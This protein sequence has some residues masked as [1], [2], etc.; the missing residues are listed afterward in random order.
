MRNFAA[1]LLLP[2]LLSACVSSPRKVALQP[3]GDFPPAGATVECTVDL[4]FGFREVTLAQPTRCSFESIGHFG[5]L[6]HDKQRLSQVGSYSI[7]PSGNY[8]LYQD[9]PSGKLFLFCR[10]S[11]TLTQLT[12]HFVG[13]ADSYQWHEDTQAVGVGF[14]TG[15]KSKRTFSIQ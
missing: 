5:Y 4:G 1:L 11:N 3:S 15:W 14:A 7:S 10:T 2:F 13:L 8:A 12:S 6:H 9:G